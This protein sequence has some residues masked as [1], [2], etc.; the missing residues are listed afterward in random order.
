MGKQR[1]FIILG[2]TTTHGD[3]VITAW[4]QDGP[5]P[6]TIDGQEPVN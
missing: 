6:F 2:D 4:G 5:V 3:Q 1:K